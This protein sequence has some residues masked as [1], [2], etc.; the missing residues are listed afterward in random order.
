MMQEQMKIPFLDA[1]N[2]LIGSSP[3]DGGTASFNGGKNKKNVST[4]LITYPPQ[5]G[6]GRITV[7]IS[8]NKSK[9]KNPCV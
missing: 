7:D 3:K 8:N 1:T 6:K 4:S 5:E 9:R 2:L